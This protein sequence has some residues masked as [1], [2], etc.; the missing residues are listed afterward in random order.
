MR[1]RVVDSSTSRLDFCLTSL[2]VVLA[3]ACVTSR[4]ME[5]EETCLQYKT[6]HQLLNKLDPVS[7]R[8]HE[9]P[10]EDDEIAAFLKGT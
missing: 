6:K 1:A 9:I 10:D 5:L 3:H 7:L 2:P 8:K 4:Y